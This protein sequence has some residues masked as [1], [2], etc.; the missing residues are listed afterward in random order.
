V[1]LRADGE[2]DTTFGGT[3]VVDTP[4]PLEG[5][6]AIPLSGGGY[7]SAGGLPVSTEEPK[8]ARCAVLHFSETGALLGSMSYLVQVDAD[9]VITS[10]SLTVTALIDTA[11]GPV[12]A[13]TV[14]ASTVYP[15]LTL[16]PRRAW[17]IRFHGDGTLDSSWSGSGMLSLNFGW[18][19]VAVLAGLPDGRVIAAGVSETESPTRPV[20]VSSPF[21][22]LLTAEGQLDTSW[23]GT[24][25]FTPAHSVSGIVSIRGGARLVTSG[26]SSHADGSQ[27]ST[28]ESIDTATGLTDPG[29]GIHGVVSVAGVASDLTLRVSSESQAFV[30]SR[31]PGGEAFIAR[32]RL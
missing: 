12:A 13:A 1:R 26:T 24:G 18:T 14:E 21:L 11:R 30:A 4:G 27:T 23:N 16:R 6:A 31:V 10:L 28:L 2:L 22:A 32:Y 29:F 9:P 8:V 17:L 25:R 7:L 15:G 5:F 3:G 20:L 19:A